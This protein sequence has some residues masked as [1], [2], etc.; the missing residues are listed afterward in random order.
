[1]DNLIA[2]Y[3]HCFSH[4]GVY[5]FMKRASNE[6]MDGIINKMRK[7]G[8][9][10]S[11]T[12][13]ILKAIEDK[14]NTGQFHIEK[15]SRDGISFIIEEQ[16]PKVAFSYL[17][18]LPEQ[19]RR[20]ILEFW[21]KQK[22]LVV[23]IDVRDFAESIGYNP[24][25]A[26]DN[27]IRRGVIVGQYVKE[28]QEFIPDNKNALIDVSNKNHV[29]SNWTGSEIVAYKCNNYI[30]YDPKALR[31]GQKEIRC[32][33]KYFNVN[34]L[35]GVL[36][37]LSAS[38]DKATN[39]IVTY[40]VTPWLDYNNIIVKFTNS[41]NRNLTLKMVDYMALCRSEERKLPLEIY[42]QLR[43]TN[44]V[45]EAT[46]SKLKTTNQELSEIKEEL[47]DTKRVLQDRNDLLRTND[48]PS[49]IIFLTYGVIDHETKKY[50]PN[51][52]RVVFHEGLDR[53]EADF[54]R[55]QAK[56]FE[57]KHKFPAMTNSKIDLKT[58]FTTFK[59]PKTKP[60]NC[61]SCL[62]SIATLYRIQSWLGERSE[63]YTS[64]VTP[65]SQR[66]PLA[67]EAEEYAS[68]IDFDEMEG[69]PTGYLYTV[70]S[71]TK[72]KN[73][74]FDLRIF[75]Y[76]EDDIEFTPEST[77]TI[78]PL[79]GKDLHAVKEVL[80]KLSLVYEYKPASKIV[81]ARYKTVLNRFSDIHTFN[82]LCR[83]I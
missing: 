17:K 12:L 18:E 37:K 2:E 24:D 36:A 53:R 19:E 62:C 52:K 4:Q 27:W 13:N 14:T 66:T 79:F 25:L 60:G 28:I 67:I 45:L 71:N 10:S 16:Q 39:G 35:P 81:D 78:I 43:S 32:T 83:K 57:E 38:G 26:I 30:R 64:D 6:I 54:M 74:T 61:N 77:V 50:I 8:E 31:R 11:N 29:P 15:F 72:N 56:G 51:I 55:T 58:L 23:W 69:A 44:N 9:I 76:D 48:H 59:L 3:G 46:N 42:K 20:E 41:L 63:K 22:D 73:D 21:S 82:T 1:M 70:L 5:D 40:D 33:R 68:C 65:K 80:D 49:S 47:R 75:I 7:G 34:A